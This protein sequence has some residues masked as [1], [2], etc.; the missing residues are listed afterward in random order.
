MWV[1]AGEV[2][3]VVWV[4]R[5]FA[6]DVRA[7]TNGQLSVLRV[8]WGRQAVLTEESRAANDDLVGGHDSVT[9][10]DARDVV[11]SMFLIEISAAHTRQSGQGCRQDA[12][13]R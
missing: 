13:Q 1:A 12:G 9:A 3:D 11:V 6:C 2:D 8:G 10:S 4:K 5:E 7:S